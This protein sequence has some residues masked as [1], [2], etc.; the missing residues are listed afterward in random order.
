MRMGNEPRILNFIDT[1]GTYSY[2]DR[3]GSNGDFS[4]IALILQ[5][6][7]SAQ[8]TERLTI[9]DDSRLSIS[10]RSVLTHHWSCRRSNGLSEAAVAECFVCSWR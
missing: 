9:P 5:R 10:C 2:D 1:G 7:H 8:R 6:L 4:R 3:S